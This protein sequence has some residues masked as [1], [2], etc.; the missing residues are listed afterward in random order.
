MADAPMH[1]SQPPQLLQD[2]ISPPGRGASH[3]GVGEWGGVIAHAGVITTMAYTNFREV[4]SVA[5]G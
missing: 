3:P 2:R 4:V 1:A 5:M